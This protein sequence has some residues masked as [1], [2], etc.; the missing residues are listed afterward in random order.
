MILCNRTIRNAISAMLGLVAL[1]GLAGC[2]GSSSS[3]PSSTVT[4]TPVPTPVPLATKRMS[5]AD[6]DECFYGVGNVNNLYPATSTCP[7]VMLQGAPS[8]PNKVNPAYVWG[9]TQTGNTLWFGTAPNVLCL[10]IGTLLSQL[11]ATLNPILTDSYVC[12]FGQ[13]IYRSQ[14]PAIP[15]ALGDVRPPQ[16]YYYN[17]ATQMLTVATPNDPLLAATVGIRSAGNENGVV[18]L[19]GPNLL[20]G[21]SLFAFNSASGAYLGSTNLTDY[22]DIRQWLSIDGVLYT[23]VQSKD[24]TGS[25]LRWTGSVANPFEFETVGM[26]DLEAGNLAEHQGRLFVTTW[27]GFGT[28]VKTSSVSGLWMSPVIPSG[29]LTSANA[30]NWVELWKVSDYEPDPVTAKIVAGGAAH[31]YDGYLYWGTMQVPLSGAA[32]HFIAYPPTQMPPPAKDIAL[33]ILGSNRAIGIFRCCSTTLSDTNPEPDTELL[34]GDAKMGVYSPSTGWSLQP[35][36]MGGKPGIYG[37]A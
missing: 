1:A 15:P 30:N 5:K 16:I 35:N 26:L 20:G 9:L 27:P 18:F 4:A 7:Q 10:V 28:G 8:T 17:T 6:P 24:G 22:S 29:G 31:S 19:G 33:A 25:V 21:V 14:H 34:Y 32:A 2:S 12:E 3:T 11:Q 23:G 13:S 36:A 37:N